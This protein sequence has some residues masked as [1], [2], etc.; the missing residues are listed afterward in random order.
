MNSILSLQPDSPPLPAPDLAPESVT[1]PAQRPASDLNLAPA[2]DSS[3]PRGNGKIPHLP[4][5]QRALINQ[6]LD[7]GATYETI[8]HKLSEQ[9]VSLNGANLTGWFHG[10]YQEHLRNRERREQL[11]TVQQQLLDLARNDE[12]PTLSLA[13]LQLAVTQLSQQLFQ[14]A[15]G[16]HQASFQTDTGHYLRMLNTLARIT[17]SLLNLKQ[18]QDEVEKARRALEPMKDPHRKLTDDERRAIVA[19]VDDIL[20]IKPIYQLVKEFENRKK[21]EGAAPDH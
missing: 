16:A 19:K 9:G 7:D 14:L 18:Y 6:M 10:G 1:A 8:I 5:E 15:P 3:P 12:S 21:P 2:L 17:K 20:G 13:G 4:E 11:T